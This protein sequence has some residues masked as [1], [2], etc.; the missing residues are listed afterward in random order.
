MAMPASQGRFFRTFHNY[1][2]PRYWKLDNPL[3]TTVDSLTNVE[4]GRWARLGIYNRKDEN[5]VGEMRQGAAS[6]GQD[7]GYL[8]YILAN[9][10]RVDGETTRNSYIESANDLAQV[11]P[12]MYLYWH[13]TDRS[14]ASRIVALT[15]SAYRYMSPGNTAWQNLSK[16]WNRRWRS[17]PHCVGRFWDN[18][19]NSLGNIRSALRNMGKDDTAIYTWD[20]RRYHGTQTH[21]DPATQDRLR[22]EDGDRLYR[23]D[24]KQWLRVQRLDL[25][26]DAVLVANLIASSGWKAADWADLTGLF[27]EGGLMNYPTTFISETT[28]WHNLEQNILFIQ[29]DPT[30]KIIMQV[31]QITGPGTESSKR[32]TLSDTLARARFALAYHALQADQVEV[33]LS[34]AV[35][36]VSVYAP[37][38]TERIADN[39]GKHAPEYVGG[40]KRVDVYTEEI[41]DNYGHPLGFASNIGNGKARRVFD[42]STLELDFRNRAVQ[43]TFGQTNGVAPADLFTSGSGGGSSGAITRVNYNG[44]AYNERQMTRD[45]VR[46]SYIEITDD[47]P[48]E[49]IEISG[50]IEAT[51]GAQ[52][53]RLA[54]YADDSTTYGTG[55]AKRFGP[56]LTVGGIDMI[57]PAEPFSSTGTKRAFS[58][59]FALPTIWNV[60][61]GQK[62]YVA[63]HTSTNGTSTGH[64][65]TLNQNDSSGYAVRGSRPFDQGP[66]N[67]YADLASPGTSGSSILMTFISAAQANQ[68]TAPT[69]PDIVWLTSTT[70]RFSWTAP[71]G[72]I[73]SYEVEEESYDGPTLIARVF[74]TVEATRTYYDATNR[75]ASYTYRYR[76]K[77]VSPDN[78]D[79]LDSDWLTAP[80]APA[81][82]TT[83]PTCVGAISAG[84]DTG[85]AITISPGAPEAG[86]AFTPVAGDV[87]L[88]QVSVK[89]ES[90][91]SKTFTPPA[92]FSQVLDVTPYNPA[93]GNGHQLFWGTVGASPPASYTVSWNGTAQDGIAIL[94]CWRGCDPQYPFTDG[95]GA[96][97]NSGTSHVTPSVTTTVR[98]SILLHM[99]NLGSSSSG[100]T[101]DVA[102]TERRRATK[103]GVSMT[104]FLGSQLIVA[105]GTTGTRT[106]TTSGSASGAGFSLVLEP[107]PVTIP[108]TPPVPG[109]FT[110]ALQRNSSGE[111]SYSALLSWTMSAGSTWTGYEID[112]EETNGSGTSLETL[113]ISPAGFTYTLPLVKGSTYRFRMRSFFQPDDVIYASDWTVYQTLNV[114]LPPAQPSTPYVEEPTG[115]TDVSLLWKWL[116]SGESVTR[117]EFQFRNAVFDML[118]GGVTD[119][120]QWFTRSPE[121]APTATQFLLNELAPDEL[122]QFRIR[123]WNDAGPG[124]WSVSGLA[125]T[126]PPR[127][128]VPITN[129]GSQPLSAV[130]VLL[131]WE[132]LVQ[133]VESNVLRIVVSSRPA[134]STA[135]FSNTVEL[136]NQLPTTATNFVHVGAQPNTEYRYQ[137]TGISD[138]GESDPVITHATT[139]PADKPVLQIAV[140]N[141]VID[142]NGDVYKALQYVPEADGLDSFSLLIIAPID[143][144]LPQPQ[145][146]A[147][148]LQ[149]AH[150]ALVAALEQAAAAQTNPALP[151]GYILARSPDTLELM[152]SEL[153][154]GTVEYEAEWWTSQWIAK[155]LQ[156]RVTLRRVPMWETA[157]LRLLET[158]RV[159]SSVM[160]AD[161][162]IENEDRD[163][164]NN[165]I[166]IE[167]S[168]LGGA[169]ATPLRIEITNTTAGLEGPGV[170]QIGAGVDATGPWCFAY[171]QDVPLPRTRAQLGIPVTIDSVRLA[172]A[173]GQSFLLQLRLYTSAP[174]AWIDAELRRGNAVIA[175]LAPTQVDGR[176][177]IPIGPVELPPGGGAVLDGD[178][179]TIQLFGKQPNGGRLWIRNVELLPLTGYRELRTTGGSVALNGAVIDDQ[180]DTGSTWSRERLQS[181]ANWSGSGTLLVQPNTR[182]VVHIVQRTALVGTDGGAVAEGQRTSSVRI[183]YRPRMP[184]I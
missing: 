169:L 81:S 132:V 48:V 94:S 72:A 93:G 38:W 135:A 99:F 86:T 19:D 74:A 4:I 23:E 130:A 124:E 144:A 181:K 116:S 52:E 9:E 60:V 26:P 47:Q 15:G 121:P 78:I 146:T 154:G 63:V 127:P 111:I 96:L 114:P 172:Q 139:P 168:Q 161:T 97:A 32:Q 184:V 75:Q 45:H 153:Q 55:V 129:L 145:P 13:P 141:T 49:K 77:A 89:N 105:P 126:L 1:N 40:Y 173:R 65:I 180:I 143:T 42:Q 159:G 104:L 88:L 62:Y 67:T 16:V 95:E 165:T 171:D 90:G 160:S 68:L 66:P 41:N 59:A 58:F 56:L 79:G 29:Q 136:T 147:D 113:T 183:Y 27:H 110:A 152:R 73:G 14:A 54:V 102:I 44:P 150:R 133:A 134:G 118:N 163:G 25:G 37:R 131:T 84:I 157:Q 108:V 140:G 43:K 101:P 33:L 148:G 50:F 76:V 158:H 167:P 166:V 5:D 80:P 149:H 91:V 177:L 17:R 22:R 8:E 170:I 34:N 11:T 103:S 123:R 164:R 20:G 10:L 3:T 21:S 46:A 156:V 30:R 175:T 112:I 57:T 53:L 12:D 71:A 24:V 106:S 82:D 119:D 18:L 176:L 61:T 107:P 85:N 138:G 28:A 125:R 39:T 137:V 70:L 36:G 69:N 100:V 64:T 120:G 115:Q 98:N 83:P 31:G 142:L 6:V 174:G 92:G 87:L 178:S 122:F 117:I 151:T 182:Y 35:N 155:I 162:A 109:D 2:P 7:F 179:Y 128:V 51:G